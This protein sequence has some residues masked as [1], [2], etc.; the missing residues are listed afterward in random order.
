MNLGECSFIFGSL[1][2]PATY[3]FYRK[4][5]FIKKYSLPLFLFVS[6]LAILGL[7]LLNINTN[8][9]PNYYLFLLCPLYS[10]MLLKLLLF[11]FKL[12]YHRNPKDTPNWEVYPKDL[13]LMAD[14]LFDFLYLTLSIIVPIEVLL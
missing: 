4:I 2:T 14:K 3:F 5:F 8:G 7:A 11:L 6:I 10:L 9:K 1:I 13:N 12:R